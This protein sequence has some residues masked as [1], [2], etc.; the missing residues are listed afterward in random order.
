MP[1]PLLLVRSAGVS[2]Q[3]VAALQR[4]PH[5]QLF[6]AEDVGRGASAGAFS[7]RAGWATLVAT[8][9]DPLAELVWVR[10]NGFTGALVFAIDSQYMALQ[11]ELQG[12]GVLDCVALPITSSAVHRLR[13]LVEA[14]PPPSIAHGPLDLVLDPIERTARRGKAVVSLSQR[15]FALLHCLVRHQHRPVSVSEILDYVWGGQRGRRGTREI[16]DVNVSQ[17]RKKLAR[18]GLRDGIRTYRG[19]GYGLEDRA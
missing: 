15:E 1:V 17:L 5:L 3:D 14:L 10:S 13:Q 19:F 2:D 9:R 12:A 11:Q 6:L 8:R 4:W 7:V 18:L 16:V